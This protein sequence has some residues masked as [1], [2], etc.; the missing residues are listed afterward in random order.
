[1]TRRRPV[2]AGFLPLA[3]RPVRE[4][5]VDGAATP[6]DVLPRV[7]ET[8]RG[9]VT[10]AVPL[11]VLRAPSTLPGP[12]LERRRRDRS[13]RGPNTHSSAV[14]RS[15]QPT[16]SGPECHVDARSRWRFDNPLLRYPIRPSMT[17]P[18]PGPL[19]PWERRSGLCRDK[20]SRVASRDQPPIST[21]ATCLRL[22][23][24]AAACS[25]VSAMGRGKQQHV[26]TE[27]S[28]R[29]LGHGD[30]GYRLSVPRLAHYLRQDVDQDLSTDSR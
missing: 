9:D 11:A 3:G 1:M 29:D 19:R 6:L 13:A 4:C 14:Q 26:G 27:A 21:P 20:G 22:S 18:V 2:Y 8:R 15:L 23:S 12:A 17:G 28:S 24:R 30:Y 5:G 10:R 7:C 25:T 16:W